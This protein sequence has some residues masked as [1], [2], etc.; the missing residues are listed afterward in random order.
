LDALDFLQQ[1]RDKNAFV[2]LDPPYYLQGK[3]LYLNYYH[4]NDHI[5]LSNF[6]RYYANFKWVLS[7]DNVPEI[8]GLYAD[9][10]LYQFELNYTA[11]NIKKA[12]ELLTHSP[13]ISFQSITTSKKRRKSGNI[14]LLAITK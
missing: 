7:Y 1:T 11:Q 13:E 8:L 14:L 10:P 5:E 12:S 6:L 9:F 4:H 2:Y 3:A